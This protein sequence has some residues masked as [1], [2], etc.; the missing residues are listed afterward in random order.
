MATGSIETHLHHS[1]NWEDAAP[2]ARRGPGGVR[3]TAGTAY[4]LNVFG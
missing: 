1:S 3:L 2:G 4:P